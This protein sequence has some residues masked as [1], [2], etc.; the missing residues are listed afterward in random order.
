MS[1]DKTK[2]RIERRTDRSH[3][4]GH[5]RERDRH[6]FQSVT[7]GLTVQGLMLTELLEHDHRQQAWASPTSCNGMERCRR[8][9]DLLAVAA[10]ELFAHRL[11]HFPLARR[12]FQRPGHVFAEL[13]QAIAAAAFTRRW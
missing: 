13:A 10:R 1:F 3:R 5:G 4:V 6:P 2:E 11:D 9:A 12:R 7:L 8:L